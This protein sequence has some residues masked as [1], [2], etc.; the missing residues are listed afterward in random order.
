MASTFVALP[1]SRGLH[2]SEMREILAAHPCECD[3]QIRIDIDNFRLKLPPSRQHRQERLF[4]SRQMRIRRDHSV[5]V[6]KK[7]VPDLSNAFK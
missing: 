3:V 1:H 5:S 4:S 7:P 2:E 6:T